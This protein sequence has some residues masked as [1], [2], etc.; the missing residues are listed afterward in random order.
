MPVYR[1]RGSRYWW[2]KIGRGIRRSSGTT[3]K[4]A[5]QALE[6]KWRHELWRVERMGEAP[7]RTWDDAA[8]QWAQDV[9][10]HRRG[11][12]RDYY[13]LQWLN[14][15]LTGLWLDEIT[16][17][18]V[19][20]TVSSLERV[21]A[22]ATY[23]HYVDL[24]RA[25][26]RYAQRELGWLDRVPTY[27]RRQVDNERVRF[28][29]DW[30]E[31]ERLIAEMPPWW[32]DPTR[33]SLLT[34]VREGTLRALEHSMVDAERRL[35]HVPARAVKG[36]KRLTLPLSQEAVEICRRQPAGEW[37]FTRPDGRQLPKMSTKAMRRIT[38]R[39]GI[40][41]FRWHDLRHT[42]ASWLVMDGASLYE[43]QRLGGWSS[44][45]MVQ[46][47]AHLSPDHLREAA[48]R[49]S[50]ADEDCAPI[51]PHAPGKAGNSSGL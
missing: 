38:R 34:G 29:K 19:D 46:R 22:P 7:R 25:V 50:Q 41:D 4:E 12:D 10:Q 35:L 2:V 37:L 14:Q 26:M 1:R 39:A 8:L 48:E 6:A 33:F 21:K 47:Y 42:W 16:R 3:S 43:V 49:V 5:A 23:N 9:G 45:A 28:L 31:A 40:S 15:Q 24:V 44:L 32:K 11:W 36:G 20:R 18:R 17:E 13:R 51:V 27:R 30:Q